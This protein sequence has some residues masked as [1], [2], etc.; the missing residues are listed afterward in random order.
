M[1]RPYR[2]GDSVVGLRAS[3]LRPPFPLGA[4]VPAQ[5]CP[6]TAHTPAQK[7]VMSP[8][9]PCPSPPVPSGMVPSIPFSKHVLNT[10]NGQKPVLPTGWYT[11]HGTGELERDWKHHFKGETEEQTEE[12]TPGCS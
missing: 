5:L 8:P 1:G 12:E 7:V 11:C 9:S 3:G 10:C 2:G 4:S 6:P